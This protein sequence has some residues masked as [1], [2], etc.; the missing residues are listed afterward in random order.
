VKCELSMWLLQFTS[1]S[2]Y[3]SKVHVRACH[4]AVVVKKFKATVM[5]TS[6][7]HCATVLCYWRTGTVVPTCY[8][9]YYRY[10]T[11]YSGTINNYKK[12]LPKELVILP[13][14]S[15]LVPLGLLKASQLTCQ[16]SPL[17]TDSG[18]VIL[19]DRQ[20]PLHKHY[21]HSRNGTA[22]LP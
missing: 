10:R 12:R 2:K 20:V 1:Y 18:G 22:I 8:I 21:V 6:T 5:Q 7:V 14:G 15:N 4:S 13:T 3:E 19:K 9:Q 17:G 16:P 11:G